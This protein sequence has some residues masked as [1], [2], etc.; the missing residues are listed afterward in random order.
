MRNKRT[1]LGFVLA[2]AVAAGL[3][4]G[5]GAVSA[6]TAKVEVGSA[7]PNFSVKDEAGTEHTLEQYKGKLVV[8]EWTNQ[9]CP[10]VKR[11]YKADTMEKLAA[12]YGAKDV[13]WLAVNSGGD[14][15]PDQTVAWKKEQGFSYATLQDQDGALGKMFDAKTT[16][17]MYV[18]D[19]TGKLVYT[20]AIDDD[21]RGGA[22][23]PKNYI[24]G[25]LTSLET[26]AAPDP[27]ETQPYGCSVKYKN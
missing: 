12:K 13:V 24:D 14:N 4:L 23:T 26:G 11:H 20:G 8:L 9:N 16:P 7:V 21:P 19:G 2:G 5:S 18:I 27:S 10:F 3:A 6:A 15:T 25:A 17:H 22:T 1:T